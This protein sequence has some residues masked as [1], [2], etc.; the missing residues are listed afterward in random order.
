MSNLDKFVKKTTTT[1]TQN[2]VNR[3][4]RLYKEKQSY[5]IELTS[6][7]KFMWFVLGMFGVVSWIILILLFLGG[8]VGQKI[9][10]WIFGF[11]TSIVLV[12]LFLVLIATM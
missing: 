12:I 1:K 3:G 2:I 4:N 7:E 5:T 10:Y 8:N 11:L 9:K 6:W